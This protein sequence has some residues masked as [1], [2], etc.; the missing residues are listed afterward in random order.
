M[1]DDQLLF[2]TAIGA[3]NALMLVKLAWEEQ[4]LQERM[5][6]RIVENLTSALAAA[7]ELKLRAGKAEHERKEA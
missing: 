1:N 5:A 4:D 3:N 2:Q 6:D 7:R